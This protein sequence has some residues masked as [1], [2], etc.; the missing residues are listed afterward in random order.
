M[1]KLIERKSPEIEEM[2]CEM[3]GNGDRFELIAR[4]MG[5]RSAGQLLQSRTAHPAFDDEFTMAL[6]NYCE[7]L[8]Q[9][10]LEIPHREYP[11]DQARLLSQN[12]MK[13]L[14]YRNPKKY[15]PRQQVDMNVNV[16]FGKA[17]DR[18]ISSG[19]NRLRDV[20]DTKLI[21]S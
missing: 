9:E 21:E 18:A 16:D 13:V 17:L 3:A 19:E 8:E 6:Y 10:L 2:A 4:Q 11:M 15:S 1:A 14:E 20:T 7:F 12:I 5:L